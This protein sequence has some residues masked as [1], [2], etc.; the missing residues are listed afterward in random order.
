M[1]RFRLIFRNQLGQPR[2]LF[3]FIPQENLTQLFQLDVPIAQS[4]Y[5]KVE[6]EYS[7]MSTIVAFWRGL[8]E[9]LKRWVCRSLDATFSSKLVEWEKNMK[10]ANQKEISEQLS[11]GVNFGAMVGCHVEVKSAFKENSA[12]HCPEFQN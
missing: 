2:N 10:K 4:F 1:L 9:N 7:F 5:L 12:I 8:T 11:F 3:L 6:L